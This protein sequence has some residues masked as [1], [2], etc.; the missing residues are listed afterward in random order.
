MK[1]IFVNSFRMES[2]EKQIQKINK[3]AVKF[4]CPEITTE[5]VKTKR[6]KVETE[7]GREVIQTEHEIEVE[8]VPVKM[9]GWTF[10]AS[11]DYIG[12]ER[13]IKTMPGFTVP[14]RF[15]KGERYC[16]HCKSSRARKQV[17]LVQHEDGRVLQVGSTCIK[18]FLGH[19]L[20]SMFSMIDE[21][22]D[23]DFLG[24]EGAGWEFIGLIDFLEIVSGVINTCGW[25]SG[26]EAYDSG[27]MKESTGATAML[28]VDYRGKDRDIRE[29]IRLAKESVTDKNRE[30]VKAAIQW[31]S[32][33]SAEDSNDYLRNIGAIARAGEVNY[34]V[35]GF[36]AS[37]LIA[38]EKHLEWKEQKEAEEAGEVVDSKWV[39]EIKKRETFQVIVKSTHNIETDFGVSCIHRMQ[40]AFGNMLVW[41]ASGSA[42]WIERGA[43]VTI[44][45]TVKEHQ[46]YN[47]KKQ[48]IVNRVAVV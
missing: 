29:A 45:A 21:L 31:A 40:D 24:G 38:H 33:I 32:E 3:K 46:T 13:V 41:F 20:R 36:A 48:T 19:D 17:W 12:E 8:G 42:N 26:S 23:E 14:E 16:D 18:D 25:V 47:D 37:I 43:A 1:T 10:A 22:M 34:K 2:L 35:K 39:G 44:K 9:N 30:E 11:V 6:V 27:G 15:Y 4:G 5:I 28:F 7:S